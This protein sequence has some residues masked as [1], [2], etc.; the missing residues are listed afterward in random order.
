M[1]V[2]EVFQRLAGG[3]RP[4][5]SHTPTPGNHGLESWIGPFLTGAILVLAVTA[6]AKLWAVAGEARMMALQDPLFIFLSR[7]QMLLLAALVEVAVIT[8]IVRLWNLPLAA[9]GMVAWI[10][11]LFLAYRL[12]LSAIGYQ[13]PC[14]CA[15]DAFAGMGVPPAVVDTV[16]G[17][18]LGYLLVGSLGLLLWARRTEGPV[19]AVPPDSM[20]GRL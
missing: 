4:A 20:G 2:T 15:G 8:V 12:G 19:A 7:R 1:K 13:G 16:T 17:V 9:I 6:I 5:S 11:L 18:M 3:R 10:A 14:G